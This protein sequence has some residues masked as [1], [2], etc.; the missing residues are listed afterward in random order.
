MK[1]E[2]A[3]EEE[4]EEEVRADATLLPVDGNPPPMSEG[5]AQKLAVNNTVIVTWANYALWDFV[6]SWAHHVQRL[7]AFGIIDE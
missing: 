3:A 5:L 2:K 4:V 1:R 7:G 6:K